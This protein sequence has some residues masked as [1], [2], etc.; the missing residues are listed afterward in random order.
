VTEVLRIPWRQ[1]SLDPPKGRHYL[2]LLTMKYGL[3]YLQMG[4]MMPYLERLREEYGPDM[5]YFSGDTGMVLRD[6]RSPRHLRND[7][8]I[9]RFIFSYGGRFSSRAVFSLDEAA[10]I[11]GLDR[12]DI[13]EDVLAEL[14]ACPERDCNQKYVHF[15]YGGYCFN[16]HYEGV[17]RNRS[18]FWLGHPLESFPFFDYAMN[19]DDEQKK[20]YRLYRQFLATLLPETVGIENATWGAPVDS[21]GVTITSSLK[22]LYLRLPSFLKELNRRRKRRQL[23]AGPNLRACFSRQVAE[24]PAIRDVLRLPPADTL[25]NTLDISRFSTL[26]TLTSLIE[27]LDTGRST[28]EEYRDEDMG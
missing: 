18:F 1:A 6:Y 2:D 15:I 7:A 14:A 4:F 13:V 19:C 9:V 5:V 25:L 11:S 23:Q 26:F 10:T 12:D 17:D 20:H 28:I 3:N 27:Y 24:V 21:P 16:W 8:D 22:R